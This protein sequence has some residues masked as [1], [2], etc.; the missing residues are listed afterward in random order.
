MCDDGDLGRPDNLPA[1]QSLLDKSAGGCPI[2]PVMKNLRVLAGLAFATQFLVSPSLA[3]NRKEAAQGKAATDTQAHNLSEWH[4]GKVLF[5]EEVSADSLKGKVVVIEN[6]GVNCPPCVASLPH[7]AELDR[8]LRDKGLRIIGAESQGSTQEAIKPLLTRAKVEYTITAGASGPIP[9]NTIPRCYVFDG[10]GLMVY[11]GFP[12]GPAF[13]KAIKDSL[14]KAKA[15]GDSDPKAT[16]GAEAKSPATTDPKATA[17]TDTP[18]AA[19]A[20]LIPTRAWTNADGREIRAA[21]RR[22]DAT[23]VTFLMPNDKEVVYPLV[24]LSDESRTEIVEA[25]RANK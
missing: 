8:R 16:A 5:G 7:L 4:I 18:V 24:K 6:W 1:G 11:T 12:G 14:R 2:A 3:A 15:G 9:G 21:V 25:A 13:E 22:V 10:Q 19:N 20:P 17:T 23:H